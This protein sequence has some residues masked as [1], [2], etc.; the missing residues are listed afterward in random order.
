MGLSVHYKGQLKKSSSL[1]HL[2]DALADIAKTEM[3]NYFIFEEQ[4]PNQSFSLVSNTENLYGIMITPPECE[5]LCISFLE[6]RRMCGIINFNI[7]RLDPSIGKE[8]I[9]SVSTKTQH[10]GAEIHKKLILILDYINT[11]YLVDFECYDEGQF[12]ET[13]NTQLLDE[14]FER[15]TNLISSFTDS[16]SI[17]PILDNEK[18][19]NYCIRIAEI[20]HKKD[21]KNG[22]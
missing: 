1:K 8:L 22:K 6:N 5:P 20:T 4:F 2:I 3:W 12:W 18:I 14:I 10:A 7:L 11:N 21:T 19:E 15:H 16:F 9:Y 13:R 17:F